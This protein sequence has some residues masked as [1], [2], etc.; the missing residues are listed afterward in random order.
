MLSIK[1]DPGQQLDKYLASAAAALRGVL[2][3]SEDEGVLRIA[4]YPSP[5]AL[6]AAA[7]MFSLMSRRSFDVIATV[8]PTPPQYIVEPTVLIG[9]N[10]PI[11]YSNENVHDQVIV[12]GNNINE[13]PPLNATYIAGSGSVGSIVYFLLKSANETSVDPDYAVL[14][15]SSS[16]ASPY[17]D[18][19]GRL[20]GLDKLLVSALANDDKVSLFTLTSL[21]SYRPH[22]LSTCSSISETI[23]PYFP[24]LT[25][26]PDACQRLFD[27]LG[28]SD[29]ARKRQS[30]MNEDEL[31]STA[32]AVLTYVKDRVKGSYEITDFV[33]GLYLASDKLVINDPRE[34]LSLLEFSG[35]LWGLASALSLASNYDEEYVQAASQLSKISR[36]VAE[37][38]STAKLVDLGLMTGFKTYSIKGL[39]SETPLLIVWRALKLLGYVE[40]Q[41][42]LAVEHEDGLLLSLMQ[43]HEALGR[44]GL[45]RVVSLPGSEVRGLRL[46]VPKEK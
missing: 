46:W 36:Y 29:L 19:A 1:L 41:S 3:A 22:I 7:I 40:P 4:S 13:P 17:S 14:A 26:D 15:I 28:L 16:Y 31:S 44:A 45:Q 32:K 43:V 23:D 11:N 18:Q 25:G 37:I 20:S 5:E 2:K 24:G 27:S 10:S 21:K 33:G 35:D 6:P 39:G 8:S 30:V 34:A 9:F 38:V 12:I 42:L